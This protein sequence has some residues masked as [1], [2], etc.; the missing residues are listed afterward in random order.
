M[1]PASGDGAFLEL[2]ADSWTTGAGAE[3]G[4]LPWSSLRTNRD[5]G[6]ASIASCL[7]LSF[8]GGP[9]PIS[10]RAIFAMVGAVVTRV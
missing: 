3:S 9:T 2:P 10:S 5:E 4:G 8:R 6:A 1:I 7:P